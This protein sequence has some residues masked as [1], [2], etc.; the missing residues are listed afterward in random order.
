MHRCVGTLFDPCC[1]SRARGV[2]ATVAM[3]LA[4]ASIGCGGGGGSSSLT[5]PTPT[6]V[7]ELFQGTVQA[8]GKAFHP[9]KVT[10][11]G[12]LN[13]TLTQAGPPTTIFMGLAVGSPSGE[14]CVP[15][16]G[17]TVQTQAGSSPQ[18]FGGAG[19]GDYCVLVFDVGNQIEPVSYSVTVSH[20]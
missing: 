15:Q 14:D 8:G 12:T 13:V 9:F 19:A 10:T 16:T 2:L 18:L 20:F 5:G 4:V 7:Q 3:G 17:A 6:A 1:R 11:P